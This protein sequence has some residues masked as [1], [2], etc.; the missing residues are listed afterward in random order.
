MWPDRHTGE[1]EGILCRGQD[2]NPE[3]PADEARCYLLHVV[4]TDI[5]DVCRPV[6]F[7]WLGVWRR[8]NS[9]V[10]VVIRTSDRPFSTWAFFSQRQSSLCMK[11]NTDLHLISRLRMSIAVR[12]VSHVPSCHV[13]RQPYLHILRDLERFA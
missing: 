4:L 1:N 10:S 5:H 9:R 13:Q 2:P 8:G 11:L 3:P 6:C 12:Q 7:K